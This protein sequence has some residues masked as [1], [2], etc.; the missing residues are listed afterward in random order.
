MNWEKFNNRLRKDAEGQNNDIDIDSIWNAIEP[1]VDEINTEKKKKRQGIFF[2]WGAGILLLSVGL[3]FLGNHFSQKEYIAQ[4]TD[5]QENTADLK[6]TE[7][8]NTIEL[9]TNTAAT[10]QDDLGKKESDNQSD[11][12]KNNDI[13]N[14]KSES[15][16][17]KNKN[18]VVKNKSNLNPPSS[19]NVNDVVENKTPI[20][21]LSS[22]VKTGN[23]EE[24]S[25]FRNLDTQENQNRNNI[26]ILNI[27][28]LINFLNFDFEKISLVDV[29][30]VGEPYKIINSK[31]ERKASPFSIGI[32][33]GINYTQRTLAEK[34]EAPNTL[35]QNRET[36]ETPLETSQVGVNFSYKILNKEKYNIEISTGLQLTSISERYKYFNSTISEKQIEG[37]EFLSYGLSTTPTEIMG[38]ITQTKT[39]EIK[40]EIFNT[41]RMVDI[42]V[43][44]SYNRSFGEKWQAGI[45]GGIFANLSL[46]TEGIIP[47]VELLDVDL[48]NDDFD[49][50]KS[51]VGLSYHLGLNFTRKLSKNWELNISPAIR[52]FGSDFATDDYELSQKYVLFGGNIGINYRF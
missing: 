28:S 34:R 16:F 45:Q 26:E 43:L 39:T 18:R 10:P 49:I 29:A 35:L 37:V 32:Y 13:T 20:T 31:K 47:D 42:P 7:S 27:S 17:S 1:Q 38:L 51:N 46:K 52:Y 24:D 12:Q 3:W 22:E 19:T 36:Y 5:H 2:W 44:I 33:G 4:H 15:T 30:K 8:K 41:Y 9:N 40:K 48:A 23:E 11:F 25:A 21:A 14:S 6:T 50:F